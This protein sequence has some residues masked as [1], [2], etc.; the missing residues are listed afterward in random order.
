MNTEQ[1]PR[2]DHF[3]YKEIRAE[4]QTLPFG[5]VMCTRFPPEPNGYLHIGSAYAIHT[6]YRMAQR[7]NGTFHLRFDDTNPLKEDI[8]YVQAIIEDMKWLGYDPE[9]HIYYGSDYSETIYDAAVQLIRKGKAYV[10]DLTPEEMKLHRGTL[11]E[12]GT[13]SP[14]RNRS[15]EENLALFRKMKEGEF[16]ASSKVLR[17]KIDM[18]SPNMTLRDPVL[19]RILYAEHYRT[20]TEWCIFPMYDFAHPIQDAIEGI[21]YSLCSIEF[22]E[23]RP[24]Y[25]WVLNELETPEPPRQREFGRLSLTGVVTS[26]R[27]LRQLVEGGYVDGWDDP[28]LPTLRGL[29]RRGYTPESIQSFVEE[30]GNIRAH[31]TVDISLLDQLLRQDLKA[32]TVSVMAVLQP[33]KVVIT[34][35]PEGETELLSLEN[36]S[37]NGAL[38]TREVPFSSTIY[39]EREDFMEHP[40]KGFHRLMPQGEVRLKGAYFIRC[41]EVIKDPVSGEV[42]E[43]RCTYDPLTKSGSGFEGRKVKGTIHWVSASHAVEADIHLYERL[44]LDDKLPEGD[45]WAEVLNPN[46]RVIVSK[47]LIEPYIETAAPEQKFQFFRHGYFAVDTRLTT[48]HQLVF[49]RIVPLKDS[50]NKR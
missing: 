33:L 4:L 35:Y 36:N 10:C 5:R 18:K 16:P 40:V 21:T 49:N 23:H 20:G 25:E 1:D 22:K 29:R 42:T 26:K 39:I 48:D 38:G 2:S 24:L 13:D 44:L 11:T 27:F 46:S 47:A 14:Y 6:N 15:I 30:V 19:Y 9:S 41:E 34:N 32:K 8:R 12:P 7:F 3:L 31:S 28:R 50:W 43:L 45:N 17:A 37:E